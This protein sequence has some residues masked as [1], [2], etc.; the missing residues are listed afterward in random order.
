M[1]ATHPP[2]VVVDCAG[3]PPPAIFQ[4][5]AWNRTLTSMIVFDDT[6]VDENMRSGLAVGA[7]H[8]QRLH[9]WIPGS[10]GVALNR[11]L[12]DCVARNEQHNRSL[13]AKADSIPAGVRGSLNADELCALQQRQDKRQYSG[14]FR[15]HLGNLGS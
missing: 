15:G 8:R 12:Q 4:N 1:H 3:G 2:D 11:I 9:E 6:F 7:E 5:G 14:R 13:R 10:A